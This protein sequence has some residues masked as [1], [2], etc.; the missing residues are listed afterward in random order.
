MS[1]SATG[2]ES[3]IAIVKQDPSSPRVIPTNPTMQKVNFTEDS[4]NTNYKTKTSEHIR[5]DRMISD[6][7]RTGVEINGGY[8]FEFQFGNSGETDQF[9]LASLWCEEWSSID[10]VSSVADIEGGIAVASGSTI[11][12]S[13]ATKT[14]DSITDGQVVRIS[15]SAENDGF[16]TLKETVTPNVYT[17]LPALTADETFG[18]GVTIDGE[19]ARNGKFYQPF[20]VERGHTDVSEFFHFI[21]MAI[22][23]F[24]LELKD[25]TDVMGDFELVGLTSDITQTA[26]GAVYND[27]PSTNVFSTAVD[28]PQ[29]AIDGVVTES[30]VVKEMD[31]TI[32]NKV[33]QKTGLGVFGACETKPHS[34]MLSGSLSAYFESSVMFNRLKNGTPFSVSFVLLDPQGN[35]YS[36][37]LPKV[38][39]DSDKINVTGKDDDVMDDAAYTSVADPDT[40]CIIQIDRFKAL[41]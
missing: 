2:S 35:G 14:P 38:K 40:K 29:I 22:N 18:N 20:F 21:G 5:D 3:Y 8:K 25:Q 11:D 16:Y 15:G 9:L 10:S 7:N 36:I 26:V 39:L 27:L 28:I 12:L 24:S 6:V 17:T 41:S 13:T 33:T 30:C 4:F 23:K 32:D 34:I 31:F 37:K 1:T 19:M